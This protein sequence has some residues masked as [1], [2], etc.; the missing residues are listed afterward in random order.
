MERE[1]QLDLA[2]HALAQLGSDVALTFVGGG[3]ARGD[4]ELLARAYGIEDRVDFHTDE[5]P[6]AVAID[7]T[8][9]ARA[10]G[11]FVER[12]AGAA[13]VTR[14]DD[15]VL[16]GERICVVTNIPAHY[17]LPLFHRIA[18]R[19]EAAGG[20][21]RVLFLAPTPGDRPWMEG[22]TLEF[23][24][25]FVRS[26]PIRL[27]ERARAL[28]L[29]LG[30]ALAHAQPTVLIAGGFSPASM[31]AALFARRRG[32]PFGI[33]S[34][35]T[36]STAAG[37]GRLR[38]AQRRLLAHTASF[39]LAYGF[40]S[41]EYLRSLDRGLRAVIVRNTAPTPGAPS[42]RVDRDPPL[43]LTVA[44][45]V[46]R[47]GVDVLIDALAL[48]PEVRCELRIV[49][50]GPEREALEQRASGDPRIVFA[51]SAAASTVAGLYR[52]ADVFLFPSRRDVFGLVLVEAMGAGL[53]VAVSP[54]PGAVADLCADGVNSIVVP[55]NCS[56]NWASAIRRLVLD[57]ELRFGLGR[58]A[59]RTIA[60]RWTIEHSADAW[61]AGIRL[62][63][64]SRR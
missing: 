44:H 64:L 26:L 63:L 20:S 28:P 10:P 41:L 57:R 61:I 31:S 43:L 36:P 16:A 27:G 58:A 15:A 38:R 9:A 13:A 39:G 18:Q 8:E 24:H 1:E 60:N 42:G 46:P 12:F 62:A 21:F 45:L 7:T 19:A 25:E 37:L 14:T 50:G 55:E 53:P 59:A 33:W 22:D 32:L 17:R 6:D 3:P 56:E 35:E 5:I 29:A 47:K 49:G 48:A 11:A 40:E 52:T 23:D 4:L 30:R 2:V 54:E 51:G 34:G